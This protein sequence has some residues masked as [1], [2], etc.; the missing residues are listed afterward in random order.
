MLLQLSEKFWKKEEQP[1]KKRYL[2]SFDQLALHLRNRRTCAGA[3]QEQTP[4]EGEGEAAPETV[5]PRRFSLH[6]RFEDRITAN[7]L[8]LFRW[9]S[10]CA[11]C[12]RGTC[13]NGF[14]IERRGER[15][16]V[17]IPR[18]ATSCIRIRKNRRKRSW[19]RRG[20]PTG[21]SRSSS[22]AAASRKRSMRSRRR[23]WNNCQRCWVSCSG[24]RLERSWW[25]IG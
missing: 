9:R 23:S 10:S 1:L 15:A 18:S 13:V 8:V 24:S 16:P 3:A 6:F 2:F 7:L 22:R 25:S 5:V 14:L 12:A 19:T 11:R 17:R 21:R 20:L 4:A